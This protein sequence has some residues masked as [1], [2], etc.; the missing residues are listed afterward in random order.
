M[1][2]YIIY[3]R[4]YRCVERWK[5]HCRPFISQKENNMIVEYEEAIKVIVDAIKLGKLADP[6]TLDRKEN[7]T[8]T[9][10]LSQILSDLVELNYKRVCE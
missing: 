10:A 8:I 7:H 1:N 3:D 9:V 6:E 4:P 2:G 5:T